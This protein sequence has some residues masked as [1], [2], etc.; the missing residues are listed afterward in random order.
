MSRIPQCPRRGFEKLA[1]HLSENF[2]RKSLDRRKPRAPE[3][4]LTCQDSLDFPNA[5]VTLAGIRSRLSEIQPMRVLIGP[6]RQSDFAFPP[7]VVPWFRAH[8]KWAI[9][10]S[11]CAVKSNASSSLLEQQKG[12][13][14]NHGAEMKLPLND[15]RES[16]RLLPSAACSFRVGP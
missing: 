6:Q 5:G 7:K 14:A 15:Y 12:A 16:R 2:Y 9:M 11:C 4:S 10:V 1:G 3:E 13:F 8:F